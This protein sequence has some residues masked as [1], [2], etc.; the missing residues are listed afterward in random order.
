MKKIIAFLLVIVFS[1]GAVAIG[2]RIGFKDVFREQGPDAALIM[3]EDDYFTH[4]DFKSLFGIAYSLFSKG[5]FSRAAGLVDKLLYQEEWVLDEKT[6][7]NCI[8]LKGL[9]AKKH[10]RYPE[11]VSYLFRAKDLY[12]KLDL[13]ANLYRVNL[14]TARIYL[15]LG[16]LEVVENILDESLTIAEQNEI[17]LHSYYR[18]W[19]D[20][21]FTNSEWQLALDFAEKA[22]DEALLSGDVSFTADS[23]SDMGFFHMLLGNFEEGYQLTLDAQRQILEIGDTDKYYFNLV[24][25][26]IYERCSGNKIPNSSISV[27]D[28]IQN[29]LS[30]QSDDDL[31]FLQEFV[32]NFDCNSIQQGARRKGEANPSPPD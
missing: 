19:S 28:S 32:L 29:R 27:K 5:E 14:V 17:N 15:S 11:A 3:S 13:Q 16:D 31:I 26:V 8:Y 10:G 9:I 2:L 12:Q 22:Y 7:A 30:E 20:I 4:K 1:F 24:N 25:L 18:L 6:K 21:A 23:L